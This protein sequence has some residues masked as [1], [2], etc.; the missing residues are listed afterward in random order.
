MMDYFIVLSMRK[1]TVINNRDDNDCDGEGDG[2][3]RCN[4]F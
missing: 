4:L 1:H 2:V 3:W